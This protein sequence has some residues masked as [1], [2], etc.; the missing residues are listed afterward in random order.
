MNYGQGNFYNPYGSPYGSYQTQTPIQ[1]TKVSG[2]DGAKAYSMP[3]NSS[4]ALFDASE[5]LMYIKTTDGAGFPTIR[6][7]SFTEKKQETAPSIQYAT[8]ADLNSAIN[9]LRE[10]LNGKQSIPT[11]PKIISE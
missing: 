2:L 3:A 9:K 8:V 7:F 4:V 1:L 11:E 10:E 5:D 6:T